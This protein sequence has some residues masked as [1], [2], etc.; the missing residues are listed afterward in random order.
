MGSENDSEVQMGCEM[1]GYIRPDRDLIWLNVNLTTNTRFRVEYQDGNGTAQ[2]GGSSL[3]ASRVLLLKILNPT[4]ADSRSYQCALLGTSVP[5]Q[6]V[7]LIVEEIPSKL[8]S[9]C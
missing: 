4:A 3:V 9:V 6:D 8:C 5:I 7:N 2:F 1:R